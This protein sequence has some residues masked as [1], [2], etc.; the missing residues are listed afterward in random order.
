LIRAWQCRILR[1]SKIDVTM[2]IYAE[3]PSEATCEALGS[4]A[5]CWPPD[6]CCTFLLH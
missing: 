5:T 1:H 4:S 2:E 6:N 3:A